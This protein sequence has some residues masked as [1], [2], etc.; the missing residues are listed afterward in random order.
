MTKYGYSFAVK[1][2]L[3]LIALALAACAATSLTNSWK[4][5]DYKGPALKKLLVVG[6]SN[7][8]VVRRTFEDG[9]SGPD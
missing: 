6:V 7:Q 2:A 9:P 4:S 5:P 1:A 8:P 3:T